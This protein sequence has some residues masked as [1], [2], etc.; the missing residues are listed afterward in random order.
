MAKF[1]CTQRFFQERTYYE[2]ESY[3]LSKDE[4]ASFQKSGQIKRLQ[5]SDP[6]AQAML[7][8]GD[9]LTAA[10]AEGKPREKMNRTELLA[11]AKENGIAGAE[12]MTKAQLTEALTAATAK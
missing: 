10:T 3:D 11:L 7:A 8:G 6:E 12:E 2:G 4:V 5:P 9:S 1:Y